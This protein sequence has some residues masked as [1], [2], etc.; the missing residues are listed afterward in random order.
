MNVSKLRYKNILFTFMFLFISGYV[1]ILGITVVG[2]VFLSFMSGNTTR[3]GYS[4]ATGDFVMAFQFIMVIICFVFGSF[5]GN[6]VCFLFSKNDKTTLVLIIEILLVVISLAMEILPFTSYSHIPLAIA[7]GAQNCV[8]IPIGDIVIGKTFVSGTL[9]T[10][11]AAIAESLVFKKPLSRVVLCLVSWA[12]FTLG[13]IV[14]VTVLNNFMIVN[15][16][17]ILIVFLIGLLC[18]AKDNRIK[19]SK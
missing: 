9:Y 5:L 8:Q 1:N 16:L 18:W 11:G 7:M 4:I 3:F 13:A 10:M 19:K 15:A 17:L 2:E 12:F 6:Y 14:G